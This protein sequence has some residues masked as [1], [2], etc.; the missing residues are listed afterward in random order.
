LPLR[1]EPGGQAVAGLARIRFVSGPGGLESDAIAGWK[2]ASPG[3]FVPKPLNGRDAF[4]ELH[5]TARVRKAKENLTAPIVRARF[6]AGN[7]V[8]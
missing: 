1:A 4:G 5:G 3:E 6:T 8:G 7:A 2:G